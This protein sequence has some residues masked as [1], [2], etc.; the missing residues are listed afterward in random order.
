M[1][2]FTFD[3]KNIASWI[4]YCLFLLGACRGADEWSYGDG[5][6]QW[7][8]LQLEAENQCGGYYQ[9]PINIVNGRTTYNSY[10]GPLSYRG[11]LDPL[12]NVSVVNDGHTV[13]ATPGDSRNVLFTGPYFGGYYRFRQFHFHWGNTSAIGSE[14]LIDGRPF[15]LEAHLVHMNTRYATDEE[16]IK[17]PDGLAVIAVLYQVSPT[18]NPALASIVGAL[19]KMRLEQS[20]SVQLQSTAALRELLP[21]N[22]YNF[23]GYDGS[24]TTPPCSEAVIWT[25]FA[26]P[27][28]VSEQQL[29]AFRDLQRKFEG[30][31]EPLVNNFRPVQPLNGRYLYR[32]FPL[33]YG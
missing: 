26:E 33:T 5:V 24:L 9:S 10:I 6:A 8:Y 1:G 3:V 25:V 32:N 30:G 23:Y 15:P 29:Q 11:Y 18:D 31:T 27:S 22:A 19:R 21:Q 20:T 2:C 14:H 7:P 17:H 13:I 4:C 16:A 12:Q 28:K